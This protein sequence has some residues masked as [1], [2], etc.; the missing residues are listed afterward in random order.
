[1]A[2]DPGGL[3]GVLSGLAKHGHAR[4]QP[5]QLGE[6][7]TLEELQRKCR[8]DEK[9]LRLQ[10]RD[11]VFPPE[12]DAGLGSPGRQATTMA[13]ALSRWGYLI[14]LWNVRNQ[15]LV[16]A[17]SSP[18]TR[19]VVRDMLLRVPVQLELPSI[20]H[21]EATGRSYMA[22]LAIARH[23]LR[24]REIDMRLRRL[25]ALE[26]RTAEETERGDRKSRRR[27]RTRLRKMLQLHKRLILEVGLHRQAIYANAFT[28]DGAPAE[29]LD[30][31]PAWWP[32]VTPEDDAALLMAL[33][34]VGPE[35]E[36]ALA[37]AKPAPEETGQHPEFGWH[38]L[39]ATIEADVLHIEPATLYH[40]DIYRLIGWMESI[41]RPDPDDDE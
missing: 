28:P 18:E 6:T 11:A 21:V 15:K 29:S 41:D 27:A 23:W 4:I 34:K 33:F 9:I 38:S 26:Q 13:G 20:G 19:N 2:R 32:K 31:A 14:H 24:I 1:M 25:V 30:D 35:R 17:A 39:M 10:Y 3:S 40:R 8:Q 22:T 16:R 37:A 12:W 5:E 36:Q 7:L